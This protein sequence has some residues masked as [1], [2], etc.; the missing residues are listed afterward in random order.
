MDGLD[1][2]NPQLP[3]SLQNIQGSYE[4]I[5]R[6]NDHQLPLPHIHDQRPPLDTG[7][8]ALVLERYH[9]VAN[10]KDVRRRSAGHVIHRHYFTIF[11]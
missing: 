6:A 8:Y 4:N 7:L 10:G 5:F 3:P 11:T 2:K 1:L 9:E